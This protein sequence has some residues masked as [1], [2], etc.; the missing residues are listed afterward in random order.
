MNSHTSQS[1]REAFRALPADVRRRA[2]RAYLL[3]REDPRCLAFASN[4]SATMSPSVSA[5]SIETWAF[6]K[7]IRSPGIGSANTTLMIASSTDRVLSRDLALV[8]C[9]EL[10]GERN[11]H[12]R[13]R[14][15]ASP[16]CWRR[17]LRWAGVRDG[18]RMVCG[19][20]EILFLARLTRFPLS[21][22]CV[23]LRHP[24]SMPTRR[25]PETWPT[26][27]PT[28]GQKTLWTLSAP[29]GKL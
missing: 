28:T 26:L 25:P 1:F 5:A 16:S 9:S 29:G 10:P 24:F 2:R 13:A 15:I 19:V 17:W 6:W 21:C 7:A 20:A 8:C 27:P 4:G 14:R 11:L 12:R 22:H 3:W 23:R 18:Q